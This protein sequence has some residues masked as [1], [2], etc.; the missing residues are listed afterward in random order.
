MVNPEHVLT[1][2]AQAGPFYVLWSEQPTQSEAMPW[3]EF[4]GLVR[5][6][7]LAA[8]VGAVAAVLG[9]RARVP[10]GDIDSRAAASLVHLGLTARLVSPPLAAAVLGGALLQ[11]ETSG[12]YW[13][14]VLG[15]V[16]LTHPDLQAVGVDPADYAR[17]AEFLA[18]ALAGG[19][20]ADLTEAVAR[21]G[22]S[23]RVLWGNVASS[24]AA[25]AAGL[26]R[27]VPERGDVVSEVVREVFA[28]APLQ[29][30]GGFLAGRGFKRA[31][32]C[33]YYRVPG[34]GYCGDCVLAN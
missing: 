22:V 12:L 5:G 4:A 10:A 29:G 7:L 1:A 26:V 16:P 18:G 6:D 31:S 9:E 34:G 15:P 32:C 8:R 13:Q 24:F 14:D 19:P 33:L 25:A 30:R 2:A 23:R 20:V 3:R 11:V 17:I 21:L 27:A 28:R